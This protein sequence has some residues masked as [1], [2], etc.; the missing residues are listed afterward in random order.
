LVALLA[1]GC[2]LAP[3]TKVTPTKASPSPSASPTPGQADV[4]GTWVYDQASQK[5]GCISNGMAISQAGPNLS[6]RLVSSIAYGSGQPLPEGAAPPAD[7]GGFSDPYTAKLQGQTFEFDA[8]G[9]HYKLT[10]KG[11]HLEGTRGEAAVTLYLHP[12]SR[13]SPCRVPRP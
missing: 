3:T 5:Q 11:D 8:G 13:P 6:I 4:T 10:A 1:A 9:F 7:T 2:T 12:D